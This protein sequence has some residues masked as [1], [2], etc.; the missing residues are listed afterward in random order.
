LG[1]F[2]STAGSSFFPFIDIVNLAFLGLPADMMALFGIIGIIF[3]AIKTF[4]LV[5][6][7]LNVIPNVLGSGGP[8]V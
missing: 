1:G 5:I 6:M 8:N 3:G 2:I 4:L 7:A